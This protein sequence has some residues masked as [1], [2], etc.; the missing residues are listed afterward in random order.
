M[1]PTG[2][3][4][5]APASGVASATYQ[6][7]QQPIHAVSGSDYL[8]E[9]ASGDSD[10]YGRGYGAGGYGAGARLA[11]QTEQVAGQGTGYAHESPDVA[12]GRGGQE[13]VA[14]SGVTPEKAPAAD[15]IFGSLEKAA[16]SLT[17]DRSLHARGEARMAG[18]QTTVHDTSTGPKRTNY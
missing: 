14:G 10:N 16:G 17:G 18:D 5:D 1:L 3:Q 12:T 11:R 15:R 4:Y 7:G 2:A 13:D 6:Q 8:V 9:N